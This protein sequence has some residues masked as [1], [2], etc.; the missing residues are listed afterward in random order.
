[1]RGRKVNRVFC[2]QA[3]LGRYRKLLLLALGKSKKNS[4]I[5]G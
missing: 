3:S 1:M 4:H 2:S 5:W